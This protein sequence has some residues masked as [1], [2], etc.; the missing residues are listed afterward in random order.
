[1]NIFASVAE[2][3]GKKPTRPNYYGTTF[4]PENFTF[5][6]ISVLHRPNQRKAPVYDV[7]LQ[8]WVND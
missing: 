3:T 6:K 8:S 1:M 5:N 7:R 4:Q 2:N